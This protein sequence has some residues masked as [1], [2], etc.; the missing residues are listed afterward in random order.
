[1][2]VGHMRRPYRIDA[3]AILKMR[4]SR[5]GHKH[6]RTRLRVLTINVGVL[7]TDAFDELTTLATQ[8]RWDVVM[9]Q[10]T[11]L[12]DGKNVQHG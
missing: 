7:S 9:L 2:T 12:E 11:G 8:R 6:A 3:C 5:T 1:M 4:G 10:E